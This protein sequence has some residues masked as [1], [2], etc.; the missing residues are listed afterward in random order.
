[1][2]SFFYLSRVKCLMGIVGLVLVMALGACSSDTSADNDV[3]LK[4]QWDSEWDGYIINDT[5]LEFIDDFGFAYK[6][7][8]KHINE[9]SSNSGVVIIK[10]TQFPSGNDQ[11]KPYTAVYYRNLTT[12]TVQLANVINLGVFTSADTETLEEA[13]AKF[14]L[15]QMGNFVDWSVVQPYTRVD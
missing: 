12:G 5:T 13:L 6:G 3:S 2:F 10:Y 4:G 14:T 8:I 11:S 15:G 1:M 9:F 7:D